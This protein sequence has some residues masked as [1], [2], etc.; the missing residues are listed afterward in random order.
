MQKKILIVDDDE[1][2]LNLIELSLKNSEFDIDRARNGEEA[3]EKTRTKKYDLILLDLMMPKMNGDQVCEEIRKVF[4]IP[5]IILSARG[6]RREY[7]RNTTLRINEYIN[8]PFDPEELLMTVTR[9]L[10]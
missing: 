7:L 4:D 6:D 5:I 2:I 10:N 3:V 8:K 1:N 9:Y